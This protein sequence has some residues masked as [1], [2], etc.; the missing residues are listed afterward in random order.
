MTGWTVGE[1]KTMPGAAGKLPA[2]PQEPQTDE[3]LL[4]PRYP[5][6][7]AGRHGK[8]GNEGTRVLANNF[9]VSI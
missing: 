2:S 6:T 7:R 5:S 8:K 3:R 9:P 1:T 4:H